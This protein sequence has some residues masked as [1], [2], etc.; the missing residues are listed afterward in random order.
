MELTDGMKEAFTTL[1]TVIKLEEVDTNKQKVLKQVYNILLDEIKNA[2]Y[3]VM[4]NG[5]DKQELEEM[6]KD[7]IKEIMEETNQKDLSFKIMD[8]GEMDRIL[9]EQRN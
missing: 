5:F 3:V 7:D 8:P 4:L 6:L 2:Q 1:K 9:Y